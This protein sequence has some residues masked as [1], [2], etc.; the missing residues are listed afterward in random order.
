[1]G[2]ELF[3]FKKKVKEL[4]SKRARHT[5]LVSVYIPQGYELSK[6]VNQLKQEQGT[7]TNIK[8]TST[9]KN[10]QAALE[11]MIQ[12]LRLFKKTPDHGMA[13]FSGNVAERQGFQDVQVY[14]IIPPQPV[15]TKIYL[16]DQKFHLGPLKEMLAPSDVY[17]LLILERGGASIGLLKGKRIDL[18]R[19]I[20]SMVFGKFKAGGQSA[21]RIARV[22]ENLTGDFFKKVA[23]AS[24]EVFGNV[25]NLHG[26]ILGGAG[27]AKEEFHRGDYLQTDIAKKIIGVRDIGAD[28]RAGLEE[29]V[30]RSKDLL[31]KAEVTKELALVKEFLGRLAKNGAV[32]YG[33]A[34]VR[35]ALDANAVDLLLISEAL[36]KYRVTL[37]CLSCKKT[38]EE[39]TDHIGKFRTQIKSRKCECGSPLKIEKEQDLIEQ[40]IEQA[41]TL[42]T[43]VELIST[44]TGEGQQLFQLGGL[45][46]LLRYKLY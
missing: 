7:A 29:L 39:T 24:R 9:R 45:G 23:E 15:R 38:F 33:E 44:D 21:A 8:S 2:V 6:I 10:V 20:K 34:D 26:I 18:V 41:E 12:H 3:E 27:P 16:C 25:D 31:A 28:G 14:S 17:G 42:G 46:A 35:K 32:A 22:R 37:R 11:R 36:E 30:E 40:L 4:A 13:I 5:E 19:N 1:M 43:K